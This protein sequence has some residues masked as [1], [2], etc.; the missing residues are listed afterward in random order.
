MKEKILEKIS[1]GVSLLSLT[2]FIIRHLRI[3]WKLLGCIYKRKKLERH[4][5]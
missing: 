3:G 1:L 4:I 5:L 2:F